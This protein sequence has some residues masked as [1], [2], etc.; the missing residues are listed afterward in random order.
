M[1]IVRELIEL[2]VQ[3]LEFLSICLATNEQAY[4][5][6]D[7]LN[8]TSLSEL[9][10]KKKS[11]L[12][13]INILDDRIVAYVEKLRQEQGV[14]SLSEIKSDKYLRELRQISVEVVEKM[15]ELKQSDDA[16]IRRINKMFADYESSEKSFDRKKIEYFTKNYFND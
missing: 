12:T 10:A 1:D 9:S 8:M 15:A 5:L 4:S 11:T 6:I 13:S 3:K 14:D 16:I 2:N 7:S